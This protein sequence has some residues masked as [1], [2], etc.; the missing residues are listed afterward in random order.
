MVKKSILKVKKKVPKVFSNKKKFLTILLL[1]F[2]IIIIV[3]IY[4][5]YSL[6]VNENNNSVGAIISNGEVT[7]AS[8]DGVVQ[9]DS[10]NNEIIASMNGDEQNILPETGTGSYPYKETVNVSGG[11]SLLVRPGNCDPS[12]V[13]GFIVSQGLAGYIYRYLSVGYSIFK[14]ASWQF[15]PN[16]SIFQRGN[17]TWAAVPK[18]YF[19]TYSMKTQNRIW[20]I[21]SLGN[22]IFLTMVLS[23]PITVSSRTT[24]VSGSIN[25]QVDCKSATPYVSGIT[26]TPFPQYTTTPSPTPTLAPTCM[27]NCR[28]Y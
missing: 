3:S 28:L 1:S 15:P 10:E 8:I 19:T 7:N 27:P 22:Q 9:I 20:Y 25:I 21:D 18:S 5:G 11:V 13:K 6:N 16:F 17:V 2:L 4:L 12:K 23:N 14:S 26:N 24:F